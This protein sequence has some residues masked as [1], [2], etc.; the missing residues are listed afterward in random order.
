[1]PRRKQP[2]K[3]LIEQDENGEDKEPEEPIEESKEEKK[4]LKKGKGD[5]DL[6]QMVRISCH[7]SQYG[8][9]KCLILSIES[10]ID[11]Q[12]HAQLIV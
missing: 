8:A 9:S 12:S 4:D 10:I 11:F 6:Y 2:Q 1:M 5:I 7:L 3:L